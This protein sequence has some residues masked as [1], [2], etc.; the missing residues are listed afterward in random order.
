V[1]PA[2]VTTDAVLLY[3]HGGGFVLGSP[4]SHRGLISRLAEATGAVVYAPHYRL[5][6]EHP[7]PAAQDDCVACYRAL[8]EQGIS[9][10]RIVIGGDSAGGALTL[11]LALRARE[12]GLPL[13]AGLLLLSPATGVDLATESHHRYRWRDP[14]LR[15]GWMR[16]ILRAYNLNPDATRYFGQHADLRGLPPM[17]IQVGEIEVLYDDSE[18]LVARARDHGV[19][20]DLEIY[21]SLWHVFQLQANELAA[22]RAAIER[23][24]QAFGEMTE[25]GGDRLT[26]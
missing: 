23:L 8:L 11:A 10:R 19:R 20:A 3:L 5:A 12:L 2:A 17:L 25:A 24:A 9:A 16:Q 7:Y 6:P 1:V 21:E 13:P 22:S 4:H 18:R 26:G 15:S 14:L